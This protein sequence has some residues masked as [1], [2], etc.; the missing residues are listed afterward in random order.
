MLQSD[1]CV[2]FRCANPRD[3]QWYIHAAGDPVQTDNFWKHRF[4]S[5]RTLWAGTD[6]HSLT[7]W[8]AH[9]KIWEHFDGFLQNISIDSEE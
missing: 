6:E 8:F 9:A 5:I 3:S 1:R 2:Y 4:G 7:N